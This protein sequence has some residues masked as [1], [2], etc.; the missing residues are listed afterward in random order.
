MSNVPD[1]WGC[2]YYTCSHCG[3]KCHASE[4]GCD[5]S[6]SYE[7]DT[8]RSNLASSGY[9]YIGGEWKKL[10]S[11]KIHVAKKEHNVPD[12]KWN[13]LNIGPPISYIKIGDTY[14]CTTYRIIDDESGKQHHVRTK[15]RTKKGPNWDA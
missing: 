9:E 1:D 6:G 4:G 5:C 8:K 13:K 10:I 11:T 15:R 12:E 3:S 7:E 14:Q 2:Y